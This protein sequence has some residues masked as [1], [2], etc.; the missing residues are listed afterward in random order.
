LRGLL[1]V[2]HGNL[3]RLLLHHVVLDHGLLLL[4]LGRSGT[5]GC[6]LASL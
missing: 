3:L 6:G 1:L 5:F 2:L 4:V